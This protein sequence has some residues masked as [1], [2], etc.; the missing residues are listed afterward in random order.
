M[1]KQKRGFALLSKEERIANASKAGKAAHDQ[2]R[3]REWTY[4]ETVENGR[5][6]GNASATKRAEQ[7]K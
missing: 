3:A 1:T 6:G 5:K 2:G 7:K 4:D